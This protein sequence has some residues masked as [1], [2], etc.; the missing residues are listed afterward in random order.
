MVH[1]NKFVK[2]VHFYLFCTVN[3]ILPTLTNSGPYKS[4]QLYMGGVTIIINN[5]F[6]CA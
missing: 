2:E 1:F 5:P 3:L 6:C 4:L